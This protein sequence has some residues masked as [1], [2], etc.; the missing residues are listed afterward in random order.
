MYSILSQEFQGDKIV[1][2]EANQIIIGKIRREDAPVLPERPE[3]KRGENDDENE[4]NIV[5]SNLLYSWCS[6]L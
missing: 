4:E 6:R 5:I 3:S 1:K 2:E